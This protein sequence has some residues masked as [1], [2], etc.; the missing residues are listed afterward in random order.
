MSARRRARHPRTSCSGH[1]LEQSAGVL[2]PR[3]TTGAL[4]S[5]I[6]NDV[7]Q[8]QQAVS[9][10]RSATL[11]RE[12]LSARRHAAVSCSTW[13]PA[14]AR[15]R[16]RRAG[17]R[18][19][20]R[21]A[22]QRVRREHPAR[23]GRASSISSHVTAEAFTGHRIVKAS[24]RQRPESQRFATRPQRLYRTNLKITSTVAILPP[25]MEF[26]GGLAVVA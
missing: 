14:R 3:W 12:G 21:P 18:V 13:T 1:I 2:Q 25:L 9:G 23:P 19:S 17:R 11:I 16:D 20:A 10:R 26:L 6:T 4:M 8:V 24:R 22:R 15:V 7:N 5:K